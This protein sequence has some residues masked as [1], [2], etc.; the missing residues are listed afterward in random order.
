MVSHGLHVRFCTSQAAD[1]ASTFERTATV[2]RCIVAI[3][4]QM[5]VGRLAS[6]EQA[7]LDAMGYL[8]A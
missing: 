3:G 1:Q 4:L 2:R 5:D 7:A 8:V 6:F